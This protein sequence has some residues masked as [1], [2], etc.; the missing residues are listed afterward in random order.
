VAIKRLHPKFAS[1]REFVAMFLD[2]ARLASRIR[3]PNVV[4]I[5]DVVAQRGEVF[6][7]MDYVPGEALSRLWRAVA[8]R[9]DPVAPRIASAIVTAALKGLQAAHEATDE[10]GHPLGIVHRDISPQNILVGIDGITRVIDFGVAKASG[11]IHSTQEGQLKGKFAYMAPERL[12][13]PSATVQSDIYSMGV[14]LWE[15]LTNQRLFVAEQDAQLV[16]KI[17]AG[18]IGAPSL[19]T[20]DFART[21]D[22][23]SMR[24]LESLDQAVLRA[25]ARDPAAR[26][27]SA[28]EMS[29]AIERCVPPASV[30]EVA[31]FVQDTAAEGL[32]QRARWVWEIESQARAR[33]HPASLLE[34]LG[35]SVTRLSPLERPTVGHVAPA[36]Q[37]SVSFSTPEP[38]AA[39]GSQR[40]WVAPA[41][42]GT[43][44][45]IVAIAAFAILSARRQATL[46]AAS[47]TTATS[48]PPAAQ[49]TS[50]SP[51]PHSAAADA[52]AVASDD[53]AVASAPTAA[54]SLAVASAP[55]SLKRAGPASFAAPRA[56]ARSLRRPA[57]GSN[58]G[59]APSSAAPACTISSSFDTSGNP[60]FVK[61]C[62]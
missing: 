35:S 53:P 20:S 10:S 24:S 16:A 37:T 2:E 52:P 7:V 36:Q 17:V 27:S 5:V 8:Q 22:A 15:L 61:E 47:A 48:A 3:H 50:S 28:Q 43:G 56:P 62:K 1:D 30:A 31:A 19:R 38:S 58:G 32:A 14:V 11:R 29:V 6:L 21:I 49:A 12:V 60:H 23:S 44:A 34:A 57:I 51:V 40:R 55:A 42:L 9:K 13:G 25:L 33:V 26:F 54:P 41:A 4:P 59:P 18:G 45:A 39:R 46:R